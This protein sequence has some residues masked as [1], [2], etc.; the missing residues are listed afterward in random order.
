[1]GNVKVMRPLLVFMLALLTALG[2][3]DGTF[4]S[5]VEID[6]PDQRAI[7]IHDKGIETLIIE[8]TLDS[9]KADVA[10]V[11]PIPAEPTLVKEVAPSAT[12]LAFEFAMPSVRSS[13]GEIKLAG[14]S[15]LAGLFLWSGIWRYRKRSPWTKFAFVVVEGA[16][17]FFMLILFPVFAQSKGLFDGGT[18]EADLTI[19]QSARIGSYETSVITGRTT[20]AL[21]T[22]LGGKSISI[23]K[24]AEATLEAYVK[25]GWCFFVAKLVKGDKGKHTP[26]PIM[27][28][29]PSEKAIY[30]MRLTAFGS[31][32][33]ALDVLY[34]GAQSAKN[35]D[36]L[37]IAGGKVRSP[38]DT[39]TFHRWTTE[40]D[41]LLPFMPVD[42]QGNVKGWMGR[43]WAELDPADM[44]HDFIFESAPPEPFYVFRH[45]DRR[46]IA[47]RVGAVTFCITALLGVMVLSVGAKWRLLAGCALV[48]AVGAGL[49]HAS[50]KSISTRETSEQSVKAE[51][52]YFANIMDYA[53]LHLPE[54]GPRPFAETLAA[55]L[56]WSAEI[57]LQQRRASSNIADYAATHYGDK[58]P[59]YRIQTLDPQNYLVIYRTYG[60]RTVRALVMYKQIVKR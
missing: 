16:I 53:L 55:K 36:M 10:W 26:H 49:S 15:L 34:I 51:E 22:W 48:A 28:R 50:M 57:D 25:E 31:K 30:P 45:E 24:A 21:R 6:I 4:L 56:N 13:Y 2:F 44:D 11:I 39:P 20:A 8:S 12:K 29:F 60:G 1:M 59:G 3:A 38:M 40:H 23:P 18:L 46:D 54:S 58:T 41:D 19:N 33:L 7:L 9:A 35:A 27:L 32:K 5:N 14:Y 42:A 47:L 17:F 52:F 37:Q 43:F